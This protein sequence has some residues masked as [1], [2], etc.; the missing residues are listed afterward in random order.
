MADDDG[1]AGEA[2]LPRLF[3]QPAQRF[4]EPGWRQMAE[5][6]LVG[7]GIVVGDLDDDGLQPLPAR[8]LRC[9]RA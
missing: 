9:A 7:L 3:L 1:Q 8:E 4:H 5:K 2:S 6:E